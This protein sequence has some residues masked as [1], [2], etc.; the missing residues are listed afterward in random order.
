VRAEIDKIL[1]G[2]PVSLP[3]CASPAAMPA[4]AEEGWWH[5]FGFLNIERLRDEVRMAREDASRNFTGETAQR[6]IALTSAFNKVCAGE[7][8]GADLAAA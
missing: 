1:A 2:T 8:D 7:P 4:E 5:I 3:A 6:L